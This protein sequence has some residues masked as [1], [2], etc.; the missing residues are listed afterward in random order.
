M[1]D[2]LQGRISRALSQ[3][4]NPRTGQDVLSSD[5]V[6]DI[7][8]TTSGKVRVSLVFEAGDDPTLARTVRQA[9]DKV[10]GVTEASVNVVDAQRQPTN[11]AAHQPTS[12][13]PLPVMTPPAPARASAPT[14]VPLPELGKIIAV[15]SGKGGV[16]K[17]T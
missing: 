9:L 6:R 8:T 7:A 5:K 11:P 10:D 17:S 16:G 13:S 12:R 4:L 2:T 15:S 14:P 1:A 3:V